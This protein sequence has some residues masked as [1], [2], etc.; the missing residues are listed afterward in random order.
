M[1]CWRLRDIAEPERWNAR[2]LAQATG[3]AYN[4]VCGIWTN[5]TRR[6]PCHARQARRGAH[7]AAE[8]PARARNPAAAACR[9]CGRVMDADRVWAPGGA[10]ARATAGRWPGPDRPPSAGD[11]FG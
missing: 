1:A 7:G 4:T 8:R 2:T 5:T 3:L 6:R 10:G 11:A 9:P